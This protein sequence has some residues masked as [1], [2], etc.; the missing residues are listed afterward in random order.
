M[1]SDH[2][3]YNIMG[4]LATRAHSLCA[5]GH[6]QLKTGFRRLAKLYCTT[7]RIKLQLC[8]KFANAFQCH[9]SVYR[10]SWTL[11]LH[12]IVEHVCGE[13]NGMAT[14]STDGPPLKHR[15]T[16]SGNGYYLTLR[17][18]QWKYAKNI[19]GFPDYVYFHPGFSSC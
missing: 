7:V 10:W 4:R 14:K 11:Q 2:S 8:L 19:W 16:F 5:R 15:E 12:C 9:F 13:G 3:S 18:K 6:Q 1:E 17:Q